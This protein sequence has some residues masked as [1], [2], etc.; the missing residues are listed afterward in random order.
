M[1]TDGDNEGRIL[2]TNCKPRPIATPEIKTTHLT[3]N[4]Y[5]SL[6][7]NDDESI[8]KLQIV[9]LDDNDQIS[10][11]N[12][13]KHKDIEKEHD[14]GFLEENMYEDDRY[15]NLVVDYL[16]P[17]E[18]Q[19]I[20]TK[21]SSVD[22]NQFREQVANVLTHISSIYSKIVA[23]KL[24]Y[25]FLVKKE[26][27]YQQRNKGIRT[28]KL[29]QPQPTPVEPITRGLFGLKVYHYDMKSYQI[30]RSCTL[31]TR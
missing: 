23:G 4:P 29:P 8:T 7:G 20:T 14:C 27:N 30:G 16:T 1:N 13:V 28:A 22:V 11:N 15:K 19:S 5:H 17:D 18:L 12:K 6:Q 31:E 10:N 26:T 21:V 9:A 3:N 2:S 25:S 24:G